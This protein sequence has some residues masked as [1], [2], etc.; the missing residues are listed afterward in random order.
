MESSRG[1]DEL[2][3]RL[4]K[5]EAS[6]K[7][8]R[9]SKVADS[10]LVQEQPRS[11]SFLELFRFASCFDIVLIIL[12]SLFSILHGLAWPLVCLNLGELIDTF[13]SHFQGR[14]NTSITSASFNYFLFDVSSTTNDSVP[15]CDQIAN[16]SGLCIDFEGELAKRAATFAIIGGGTFV[17]A[18]FQVVFWLVAGQKQ[19]TRLRQACFKAMLFQD[20]SWFD[21][22]NHAEITTRLTSDIEKVHEGIGDKVGV[23]VQGL[24]SFI[25]GLAIAFWKSWEMTIVVL[26][27][28]PLL[29]V[30]LGFVSKVV[31]RYSTQ[32]QTAYARAGAVASEVL[33]S[34]RTVV[35]FGGQEQETQRYEAKL[36]EAREFGKRKGI[37]SGVAIGCV[38]FI[39][40]AMFAIAFWYGSKLIEEDGMSPGTVITTFYALLIGTFML[41]YAAPHFSKFAS[42]R[43]AAANLFALLRQNPKI[44]PLSETGLRLATVQGT[45]EVIDVNF[46]YPSRDTINVL[47]SISFT[48]GK[49]ETVA[50]VGSS[51][52]GKSTLIQLIQRF[53]DPTAGMMKLDGHDLKTLNIGWLRHQIGVVSQE[54]VLFD[55]T[56]EKNIMYGGENVTSEEVIAAAKLANAH[57]FISKLPKGYQ[58]V[59]GE[60]GRQLSGGQKQR[61]A[62]ARAIVGDPTVL[63]LDEATSALDS[64]SE[65]LVQEALNKAGA[66]RTTVVVAHRLSTVE[67]ADLILV[68]EHG[69]VAERGTHSQLMNLGGLYQQLVHAQNL[70]GDM[71]DDDVDDSGIDDLMAP[72]PKWLGSLKNPLIAV[73]PKVEGRSLGKTVSG[74]LRG[75]RRT[76]S[77]VSCLSLRGMGLRRS[78]STRSHVRNLSRV[79]CQTDTDSAVAVDL[80]E[81]DEDSVYDG[82][83]D[84]GEQVTD[85]TNEVGFKRILSMNS[86]EWKEIIAGVVMA[87]ISGGTW[88]TFAILLGEVLKA[89]GFMGETLLNDSLTLA[90]AFLAVGLISGISHFLQTSFFSASGEKLTMRLR[91]LS[92]RS[93]LRQEMGWFDD[94]RHSTGALTSN[95]AA[96]ASLVQGAAGIQ[97]GMNVDM[98]TNLTAGLIVAF[99]FGWKLAFVILGCMPVITVAGM[100]MLKVFTGSE[101]RGREH[102]EELGKIATEATDNI[103]TVASLTREMTFYESYCQYLIVPHNT[104]IRSSFIHGLT[105]ALTQATLFWTY[106]V[107]FRF[108]GYLVAEGEIEYFNVFKVFNAIVFC[109]LTAGQANTFAPNA[110]KAKAAAVS[111]FSLLDR[112]PLIDAREGGLKPPLM[113]G[114]VEFCDVQFS[115]PMRPHYRVLR[116]MNV[117]VNSGQTLAIVGTSGCGKSTLVSL[118]E[119]FYDINGGQL[120][121]DRRH[122]H[123]YDL[124]W[125]RANIGIVTQEPV[126]F[127]CSIKE[128]ILYGLNEDDYTVEDLDDA[129]IQA[130]IRDFIV[131]L[132]QGYDTVIGERGVQLSGGQRQRIAIARAL[133]RDP[134]MLLLDEATS[135]L[136]SE[137]E[138]VVQD[139]LELAREGR[140]CI[141]IAHRLST[142]QNAD[143]IA[144]IRKGQLVEQGKHDELLARQ[145]AY[146][147]LTGANRHERSQRFVD[148][149]RV[150]QQIWE[151]IR[152]TSRGEPISDI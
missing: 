44:N 114:R 36:D 145:G 3:S 147:M 2:P 64:H 69:R 108:G 86:Q 144:V 24:S 82:W 56:V 16:A 79:R 41:G 128:N 92:F 51:G 130:N 52:C 152:W 112:K 74:S 91:A 60:R 118:I 15:F 98:S 54:P 141:I 46:S 27:L 146:Y 143:N 111:I 34:I 33:S 107:A 137:S 13:I 77:Q 45:V 85:E 106:A 104:A 40:F 12:G 150:Q 25:A 138:K 22:H 140:T 70:F 149:I 20:I 38:Y 80:D 97:I 135:A 89:Y 116:G 136:D 11:V 151:N 29:I 37:S 117:A 43:G 96:D 125:L 101:K 81:G 123:D 100:V 102:S 55:T 10:S 84:E 119:R 17:C 1:T 23:V 113:E 73:C 103:R 99:V 127:N 148:E 57:E 94:P 9:S 28:V 65:G 76:S 72:P 67:K 90:M 14:N 120:L 121:I 75:M 95:L 88:P 58:T 142:I 47:N 48:V 32:E 68:I 53:Y 19:I 31:A 131:S 18:F 59:V 42:A 4:T 122:I 134:Q 129:A 115:Y 30:S 6:S 124:N 8:H 21:T 35:A 61:V 109:A 49:G 126:L 5:Q 50:I 110:A 83:T 78:Q 139:A 132:P 71:K 39:V 133:M 87:L 26:S 93:M 7:S 105:F 62:I 66:G 63:L